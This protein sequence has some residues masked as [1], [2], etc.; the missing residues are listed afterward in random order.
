ML[1]DG[2][3]MAA[4]ETHGGYFEI[5]TTEDWALANAGWRA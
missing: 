1:E 4:V 2:V 3:E 5:D